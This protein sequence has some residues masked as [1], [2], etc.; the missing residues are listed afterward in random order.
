MEQPKFK[1]KEEGQAKDFVL[2]PDG[3]LS[4]SGE[5]SQQDWDARREG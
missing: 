5:M 2:N 1:E 3:S 4:E